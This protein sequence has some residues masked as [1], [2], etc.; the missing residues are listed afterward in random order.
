[1]SKKTKTEMRKKLDKKLAPIN[2]IYLS[3]SLS[4]WIVTNLINEGKLDEA[5]YI[6]DRMVKRGKK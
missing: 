3:K 1:M 6:I 4:E 5:E 2:N